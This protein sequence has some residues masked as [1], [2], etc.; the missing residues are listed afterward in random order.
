MPAKILLLDIETAPSVGYTWGPKYDTNIIEYISDWF[1]LS[2][3][4][5]WLDTDGVSVSALPDY[6]GYRPGKCDDVHLIHDL[7]GVLDSAD[8]VVAHNGDS[9]DIKKSNSRFLTHGLPP[10][11][12]YK[13]VDTLKVAR[14]HFKFD[15]NKLADLA[16]YLEIGSKVPHVGFALWRGCM[17]GDPEA[18]RIMKEYNKQDVVLLEDIY[19]RLRPWCNHPDVNLY[20]EGKLGASNMGADKRHDCPACGSSHVQRRGIAVAR[21]RRY[22]RLNC[23]S[24]GHWFQGELMK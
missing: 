22:Q 1:I 8:I 4:Y 5:K 12:D 14:R 3:A 10:P 21:T 13:T 23:Q 15:S 24:C 6:K 9:F 17:E 7:H 20:G 18:W 19:L 2:F 16:K 11:S